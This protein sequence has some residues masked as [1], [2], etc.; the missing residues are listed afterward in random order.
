[1]DLLKRCPT[2]NGEIELPEAPRPRFRIMAG[3]VIDDR[4]R[5]VEPIAMGTR[6]EL[7]LGRD[8]AADDDAVVVK[9]AAL[10]RFDSRGIAITRAGHPHI[11]RVVAHGELPDGR[12][13]AALDRVD[14]VRLRRVLAAGALATEDAHQVLLDLASAL[15]VAHAC[16]VAHGALSPEHVMLARGGAVRLLG[17]GTSDGAIDPLYAAPEQLR[18]GRADA[19]SDVFAFAAIAVELLTGTGPFASNGLRVQDD[20]AR[21]LGGAAPQFT[22]PHATRAVRAALAGALAT[23]PAYRTDA[24]EELVHA[25]TGRP[26]DR[27][28]LASGSGAVGVD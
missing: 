27:R 17:F 23:R 13:Y 28:W 1:M 7:W 19:R 26:I 24:I 5:L 11:V 15:A 18:G 20:L 8:L 4:F 25:I 2:L 21:R 16:D 3:A 9:I 6:A 14:G 10:H 12:P 22:L